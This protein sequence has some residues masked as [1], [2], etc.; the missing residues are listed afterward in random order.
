MSPKPKTEEE[1]IKDI[2]EHINEIDRAMRDTKAPDDELTYTRWLKLRRN[3]TR[4]LAEIIKAE[5]ENK[6]K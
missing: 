1:N 6:D 2:K 4:R 5:R 3:F